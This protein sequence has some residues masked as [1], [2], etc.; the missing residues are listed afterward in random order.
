MQPYS[1]PS[2]ERSFKIALLNPMKLGSNQTF[3][4]TSIP[5]LVIAG[6]AYTFGASV[7]KFIG[8]S[9]FSSL[10]AYYVGFPFKK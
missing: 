6:C 3:T 7:Q 8:P 9:S 2:G 1:I 4:L 10:T 5:S